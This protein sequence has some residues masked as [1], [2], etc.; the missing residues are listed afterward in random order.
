MALTPSQIKELK[1]QLLSQIKDLPPQR[2]KEAEEQIESLSPESL[3]AMLEEQQSR[4]QKNVFRMIVNSEI[5]S[6]KISENS[7]ALA[8]LSTKS[9]SKGH[10][11]IIPKISVE[12]EESIPKEAH[13]LSEELSKKLIHSLGA[14]S[15]SIIPEKIFGEMIINVIPIY[16]KEVNLKSKREDISIE[17]LEKL[18]TSI[19]IEK[20]DKKPQLIIQEKKINEE[21]Q[22]LK[23]K[24]RIP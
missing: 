9:L 11:I 12:D 13:K 23:L 4:N 1:I 18:K 22:P 2:R 21:H 19:N 3:E 15:T 10:S 20:I 5:P 24:R 8:V 17:D 6:V 7:K 16:E 14:K